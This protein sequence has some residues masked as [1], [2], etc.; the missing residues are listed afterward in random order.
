MDYSRIDENFMA[1]VEDLTDYCM[2]QKDTKWKGG[3][4]GMV[5][6]SV[7][8]DLD[9]GVGNMA[10]FF[11]E[12]FHA[13]QDEVMANT[14]ISH[15]TGLLLSGWTEAMLTAAVQAA[16][17]IASSAHLIDVTDLPEC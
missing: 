8:I 12:A 14:L 1:V 2:K 16:S 13:K 3:F 9:C 11:A 10:A 17:Q 15:L 4:S 6:I 5:V 7:P